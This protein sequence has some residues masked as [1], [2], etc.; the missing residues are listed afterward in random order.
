MTSSASNLC[1]V[2]ADVAGSTQLYD[3]LGDARAK[4]AIDR[5]ISLMKRETLSNH[6]RVVKTIGD[7][8]MAVFEAPAHGLMAS[9]AIQEAIDDLPPYTDGTKLA[10]RIGFHYGQALLEGGDVF[11]DSVNTAARMTELASAGQI[12]TSAD[13]VAALPP[14]LRLSCREIDTLPIKGKAQAVTICEVV[15]QA[16]AELTMVSS[17]VARAPAPVAQL[18]LRHGAQEIVLGESRPIVLFG[19]APTSDL[20]IHDLHASR[21]HARIELRRDKFTLTDLSS[22]GT[23]VTFQD[24]APLI[25]RREELLLR[26]SGHIGFG[27]PGAGES[28]EK[29][30]FVID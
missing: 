11:G 24:H 9:T 23:Y 6:G 15:W 4:A 27:H 20:V 8:I 13:T 26:G 21:N 29:I 18:T 25:L 5:C 14:I 19:R 10:I 12:I 30:E 3:R 28:D 1:I 2:F 17:K 7:E 16:G 22:N